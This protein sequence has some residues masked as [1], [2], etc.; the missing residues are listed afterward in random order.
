MAGGRESAPSFLCTMEK[1]VTGDNV[2]DELVSANK[3]EAVA[4]TRVVEQDVYPRVL[5]LA[6]IVELVIS[7]KVSGVEAVRFVGDK[8]RYFEPK[9]LLV[10][11]LDATKQLPLHPSNLGQQAMVHRPEIF[12]FDGDRAKDRDLA[13]PPTDVDFGGIILVLR[14]LLGEIFGVVQGRQWKVGLE[15]EQGFIVI[16]G[17]GT[18]TSATFDIQDVVT[19]TQKIQHPWLSL[20]Q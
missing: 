19:L 8:V 17:S 9:P 10:L 5:I 6:K 12:E 16:K 4:E 2:H 20:P 18:S 15:S 13:V 3:S 7:E 1:I 11:K 14:H